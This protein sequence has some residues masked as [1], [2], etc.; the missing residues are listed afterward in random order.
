MTKKKIT[1]KKTTPVTEPK[2]ITKMALLGSTDWSHP[3]RIADALVGVPDNTLVSTLSDSIGRTVS[4][5][6]K[7]LGFEQ[8]ITD[9][10]DKSCTNMEY[11]NIFRS[12]V[13]GC[14][15]AVLFVKRNSIYTRTIQNAI[16]AEGVP[17]VL[18][19]P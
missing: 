4:R 14:S 9:M 3:N 8:K 11:T 7:R 16:K 19:T 10:P 17:F 5:Y 13:K 6:T 15:F 1:T 12:A 2:K 18:I